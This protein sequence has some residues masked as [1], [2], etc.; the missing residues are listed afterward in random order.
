MP[1]LRTAALVTLIATGGAQRRKKVPRPREIEVFERYEAPPPEDADP[2]APWHTQ[3]MT[4][5]EE[6]AIQEEAA[7]VTGRGSRM[8]VAWAGNS[9]TFWNDLPALLEEFADVDRGGPISL[10][11]ATCVRSGAGLASLSEDGCGQALSQGPHGMKPADIASMLQPTHSGWDAVNPNPNPNP[12]PSYFPNPNPNHIP[13]P[14]PS[15]NPNPNPNPN[16]D[17]NPARWCSRTIPRTPCEHTCASR[18][19]SH[20][21]RGTR[22]CSSRRG[23]TVRRV[24]R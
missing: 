13:S 1:A 11:V 4:R 9:L 6:V 20:C 7:E 23:G 18:R 17:L 19:S 24:G 3:P 14:S 8:R 10:A 2:N 16:P 22:R 12:N 5:A 21:G 15:P